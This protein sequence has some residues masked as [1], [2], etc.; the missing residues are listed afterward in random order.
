M[1]TGLA[2]SPQRQPKAGDLIRLS[3]SLPPP[4]YN[5]IKEEGDQRD[6]SFSGVVI[7]RLE[8]LEDLKRANTKDWRGKLDTAMVTPAGTANE[9]PRFDSHA[10]HAVRNL[11]YTKFCDDCQKEIKA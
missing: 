6:M 4:L 2:V 3:V 5:S 9:A 7:E 1:V 8:E 11:G 10:G